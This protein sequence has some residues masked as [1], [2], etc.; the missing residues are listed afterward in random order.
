M[1]NINL[2][3]P[4]PPTPFFHPQNCP[5]PNLSRCA[6]LPKPSHGEP[7]L[8]W[9]FLQSGSMFGPWPVMWGTQTESPETKKT[10][11]L[12]HATQTTGIFRVSSAWRIHDPEMYQ[13]R[14][15]TCQIMQFVIRVLM[16]VGNKLL[17]EP[18]CQGSSRHQGLSFPGIVCL[19]LT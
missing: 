13:I 7:F 15:P 5:S 11:G 6:T 4:T 18:Q 8:P 19:W 16:D 1:S 3:E 9:R 10:W 12:R 2:L 17:S 14:T